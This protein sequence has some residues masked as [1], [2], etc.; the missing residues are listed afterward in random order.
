MTPTDFEFT[1]TMPGDARL[2]GAVRQLAAQAAG[3]A[4]LEADVSERLAA[5]V[6]RAIESALAASPTPAPIRVRFAGDGRTLDVVIS[7][8]A[9]GA[10]S[11]PRSTTSNGMTIDWT[12]DG[13][14][15]TCHI[16]QPISA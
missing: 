4:Q 2:V 15:Q 10:G 13:A 3:Y 6:E 8:D 12:R 11:L 16:R 7:S 14:G 1:M 5:Q 9:A